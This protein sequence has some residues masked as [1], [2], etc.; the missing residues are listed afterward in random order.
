[1]TRRSIGG[2]LDL[3]ALDALSGDNRMRHFR[4]L[5]REHQAIAVHRLAADGMSDYDI[6]SATLLA[7]EQIRTILGA[8]HAV[9]K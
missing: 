8:R 3:A 5:T 2:V 7:V 6:S 9:P 1:M 4:L